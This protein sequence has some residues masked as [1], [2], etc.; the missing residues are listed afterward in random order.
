VEPEYTEQAK[1]FNWRYHE[2][3][4]FLLQREF[5]NAYQFVFKL[6]SNDTVELDPV[7]IENNLSAPLSEMEII[8]K[9]EHELIET[10]SQEIYFGQ[11]V[12][13]AF[14]IETGKTTILIHPTIGSPC[15]VENFLIGTQAQILSLSSNS[16]DN[17]GKSE[18]RDIGSELFLTNYP[19]YSVIID[20]TK[21]VEVEISY[22]VKLIPRKEAL[23]QF[24]SV[25][26]KQMY[27]IQ[28]FIEE[29]QKD[30][31]VLNDQNGLLTNEIEALMH[32]K[33]VHMSEKEALMNEKEA[34]INEKEVLVNEREVLI[35]ERE[36]LI[37]EREALINDKE[38]LEIKK[39]E[40]EDEAI[41]MKL[42]IAEFKRTLTG[43]LLNNILRKA[44][45]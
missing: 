39:K 11:K 20:S 24:H 27:E 25:Q 40:I 45:I 33:R 5:G 41:Q 17:D 18:S 26:S 12:K 35:N 31:Q 32:E 3:D 42:T 29:L 34:L 28:I 22:G 37:N 4:D 8:L 7:K 16:I 10:I 21:S 19:E 30:R 23:D 9:N 1:F 13:K 6:Q 14:K 43:K 36:V 38:L 44:K 15:V 2:L